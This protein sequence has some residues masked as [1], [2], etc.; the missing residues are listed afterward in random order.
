MTLYRKK[1]WGP[2]IIFQPSAAT[3]SP[4]NQQRF[5][6][7]PQ[8]SQTG[9]V[10]GTPRS[11]NRTQQSPTVSLPRSSP[12]AAMT[13]RSSPATPAMTPSQSGLSQIARVQQA[14]RR[15]SPDRVSLSK[16]HMD[17][18]GQQKEIL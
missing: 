7:G 12:Q 6:P 17:H 1:K 5:E 13:Q 18:D 10:A 16:K 2:S 3:M 4:A 15:D 11:V 9:F 8:I 14:F